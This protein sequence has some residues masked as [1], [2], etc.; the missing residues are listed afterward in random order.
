MEL[1]EK[2]SKYR[3]EAEK[4]KVQLAEEKR[5]Y[6]QE[7]R[8]STN[9]RGAV[10]REL[11]KRAEGQRRLLHELKTKQNKEKSSVN[12]Q[13]EDMEAKAKAATMRRDAVVETLRITKQDINDAKEAEGF[14]KEIQSYIVREQQVRRTLHNQMEDLKGKIRV[15][16]R[17][18]PMSKKEKDRGCTEV[19]VKEGKNGIKLMLSDSTKQFDFDQ[20]FTGVKD[21]AQSDIF[22]DSK[23][24]VMSVVDGYNVCIFAYG[25]TGSGKTFTMI[26]G[27][28]IEESMTGDGEFVPEAGIAP[29]AVSELFRLLNERS[30]QSTYTVDVTMFQIYRDGLQDLLYSKKAGKKGKK[31]AQQ[32]DDNDAAD[33]KITLAQHSSTGLVQVDGA[34]TMSATTP[35]EVMKIFAEG[36]ARRKVA[37]TQMNA[38]SSRSHLVCSLV[39]NIVSK[40]SGKKTTGKLTLVDLA[41]SERVEKSGASGDALK[42]A[43]SINK[44]LSALGDVIASL[45]SGSSHIPYRNHTLTMLM[46]DSIGG[47]AKTLMFVNTSPADYNS[48][49][50]SSS[51]QFGNRCK[52]ITNAVAAPP[53]VQAAQLKSLQKELAK[54][55]KEGGS[56]KKGGALDKPGC[57]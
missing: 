49:E 7:S 17:V 11:E 4:L 16:V 27:C 54:L 8:A 43:Q 35:S 9:E 19:A 30:E 47:N 38:E 23:H 18:R 24:L 48:S 13:L 25:Q 3:D 55:K 56:K 46:S 12:F 57:K 45:T 50:T 40:N 21:N 44:S 22:R 28:S 34:V 52:D 2:E 31:G 53:H 1:G 20:V 37:S 14:N 41:G 5:G 51:L 15:Y 39:V 36:S 26:G 6:L 10:Q 32:E 33:L 42:E 29:R